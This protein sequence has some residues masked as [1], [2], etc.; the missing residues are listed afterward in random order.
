MQNLVNELMNPRTDANGQAVAV[1][2]LNRRAAEA[3]VTLSARA[4]QDTQG[5]LAAQKD[6]EY[7]LAEVVSLRERDSLLSNAVEQYKNA[8]N[9][10]YNASCT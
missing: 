3:I 2:N 5:R 8:M 6:A 7:L 1:T 4:N 10:D 9:E